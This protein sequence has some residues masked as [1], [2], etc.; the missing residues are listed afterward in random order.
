MPRDF[1]GASLAEVE[2]E[3][4]FKLA[5]GGDH[6]C[7]A[8]QC[9]NCQSQNIRGRSLVEGAAQDEAF[10]SVV[11]WATLDAF[12]AHASGTVAGHV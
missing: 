9:P 6:L 3:I 1:H 11:I 7:S 4:R 5:R 10:E 12:W 8:F 2:D